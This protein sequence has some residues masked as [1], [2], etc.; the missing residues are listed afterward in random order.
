MRTSL[1]G[2]LTLLV[3]MLS[4]SSLWANNRTT[5]ANEY[6]DQH[7]SL[8]I[9]NKVQYRIP[10]AIT[11]AQGLLE[12]G[13]GIGELAVRA[14]N[15]FGIKC[16]KDWT[17]ETYA[18]FDDDYENGKLIPSCFRAYSS[19]EAS[20]LDHGSF[21]STSPRYQELFALNHNNYKAWARGLQKC[22]YAT[23][24]NYAKKLIRTIEQYELHK[25]DHNSGYKIIHQRN[26]LYSTNPPESTTIPKDYKRHRKQKTS[27]ARL[28]PK[29]AITRNPY[30]YLPAKQ[31]PAVP[32][33][34]HTITKIL[35]A[36]TYNITRYLSNDSKP[37]NYILSS[38]NRIKNLIIKKYKPR[39]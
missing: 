36:P 23:D 21:L 39:T 6:I 16:K 8:A 29:Q 13:Y 25:L 14:N 2:H 18:Y 35:P 12:S 10:A 33:N 3:M 4:L 17:G 15:H 30:D 26:N 20:Y 37:T 32:K 1:Q 27:M 24:Q 31:S 22:G 5:Q 19:P 28:Q 7:K 34:L 9:Q 11:L 38:Q